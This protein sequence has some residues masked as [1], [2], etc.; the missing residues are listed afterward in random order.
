MLGPC[1][2]LLFPLSLAVLLGHA[3]F[4]FGPRGTLEDDGAPELILMPTGVTKQLCSPVLSFLPCL[5]KYVQQK[6]NLVAELNNGLLGGVGSAS[7]E[8]LAKLLSFDRTC[9]GTPNLDI[10]LVR[11]LA[12]RGVLCNVAS[13]LWDVAVSLF[14]VVLGNFKQAV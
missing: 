2:P 10:W 7:I 1:L 5:D 12:L 14:S 6:G 13:M 3:W 4:C 8:T 11:W 9:C